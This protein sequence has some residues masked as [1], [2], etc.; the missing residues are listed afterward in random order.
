[1]VKTTERNLFRLGR[2][3]SSPS[4]SNPA[5]SS[6]TTK[7]KETRQAAVAVCWLCALLSAL[8]GREK[9]QGS[10]NLASLCV[11]EFVHI[12][13][14]AEFL[15]IMMPALS[16]SENAFSSCIASFSG[17]LTCPRG[18]PAEK[19]WQVG[20]WAVVS[21]KIF[22]F[23]VYTSSF[24]LLFL[25]PSSILPYLLSPFIFKKKYKKRKKEEREEQPEIG[26]K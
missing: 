15:H 20:R 1:M 6:V 17:E 14:R 4:S 16:A 3:S 2:H 25:T 13:M 19:R 18:N 7:N 9:G 12:M 11:A 24:P 10:N 8:R 5:F 21:T 22:L 23:I 26:Q